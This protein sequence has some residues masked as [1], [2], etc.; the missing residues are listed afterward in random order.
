M[1]DLH[2]EFVF[3]QGF[4]F[5]AAGSQCKQ[6]RDHYRPDYF[7]INPPSE[8]GAATLLSRFAGL[9]SMDLIWT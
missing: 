4:L 7:H 5:G 9:I 3:E 2:L 6:D 1:A 8:R